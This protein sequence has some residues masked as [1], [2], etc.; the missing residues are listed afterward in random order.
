[1]RK[2]LVINWNLKLMNPFPKKA[3]YSTTPLREEA[4]RATYSRPCPVRF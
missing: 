1:M 4:I 2:L 3:G